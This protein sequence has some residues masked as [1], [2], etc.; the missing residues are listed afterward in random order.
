MVIQYASQFKKQYKK[1]PKKFQVQFNERLLLFLSDPIMPQLH[2][3]PLIGKFSG[4]WS[5]NVNSDLRALYLKKGEEIVVFA[6]IGSH[7]ELYD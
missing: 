4:Y 6:L 7:T 1:L 3:H 5:L 2:V